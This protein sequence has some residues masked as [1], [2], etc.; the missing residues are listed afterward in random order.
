MEPAD[1][2]R[3][4]GRGEIGPVAVGEARGSENVDRRAACT[5][6]SVIAVFDEP[7]IGG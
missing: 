6:R 1:I 4:F 5:R 7:R 2:S 3:Y